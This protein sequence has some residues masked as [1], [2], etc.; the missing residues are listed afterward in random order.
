MTRVP[1]T[2]GP[3]PQR[4]TLAAFLA[5]VLLAL[6]GACVVGGPDP[7]PSSVTAQPTVTVTTEPMTCTEEAASP[8]PDPARGEPVR[9]V[10]PS[11]DVDAT[12]VPISLSADE[13]LVPPAD[14]TQTGWWSRS[15]LP[16]STAGTTLIAGHT[17]H[18]GGGV[19]DD[20]DQLEAGD[21]V[22]VRT[23]EGWVAYRVTEVSDLTKEQ[24]GKDAHELFSQDS[25]G[26]LALVTCSHYRLGAYAR[27]TVVLAEPA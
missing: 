13:T 10:I 26:R 12:V 27:N 6:L 23:S 11:I 21:V 2:R 14:V 8:T 1:R 15:A 5:L 4:R 9:L 19:F 25:D 24:V 7:A 20:L 17:V 18:A 22:R 3:A 16:G